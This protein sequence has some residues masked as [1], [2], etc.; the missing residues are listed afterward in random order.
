[1]KGV[2]TRKALEVI[3]HPFYST[4]PDDWIFDA[5]ILKFTAVPFTDR[6]YPICLPRHGTGSTYRGQDVIGRSDSRFFIIL[7]FQILM[8]HKHVMMNFNC[9]ALTKQFMKQQ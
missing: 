5:A 4:K 7:P 6:I 3:I 8:L 1:M 2:E 9:M